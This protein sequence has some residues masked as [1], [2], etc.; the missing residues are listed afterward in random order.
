MDERDLYHLIRASLENE[1]PL[2]VGSAGGAGAKPNVEWTLNIVKNILRNLNYRA[3]IGAFY[4]DI[5]NE[6]LIK[7]LQSD[8]YSEPSR[9][10]KS[11]LSPMS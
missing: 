10:S 6:V 5:S 7:R 2:I 9:G 11:I 4:S 1:I 3:R 8:L